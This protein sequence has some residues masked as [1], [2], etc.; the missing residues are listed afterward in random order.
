MRSSGSTDTRIPRRRILRGI[1]TLAAAATASAVVPRRAAAAPAG[2][3]VAVFGA[4]PGGMSVAHELAER[5]FRVDVYERL[6]RLGGGVRSFVTPGGG[7]DGR[8][9]LPNTCGGHFFLPGYAAMPDLLRRIPTGDGR[10]VIDRLTVSSHDVMAGGI[11]LNGTL[12]GLGVPTSPES[13]RD[14]SLDRVLHSVRGLLADRPG[15]RPTDAELLAGKIAAWVTSGDLR[16]AGQLEFIDLENGFFRADRLSPTAHTLI[17][18]L[19]QTT[20]TDSPTRG[21]NALTLLTSLVDQNLHLAAGRIT[22]AAP[23]RTPKILMDGPE[24]EVWFDPWARHLES[25]GATFHTGRTLTEI[26]FDDGRITGA[27]VRDDNGAR[28]RVEADWFVLAMPPDRL[29]PLLGP[30]LRTADPGLTGIDRLDLSVE[31]GFELFFRDPI[32]TLGGQVTNRDVDRDWLLTVVGLSEIWNLDLSEYGDGRARGMISVEFNNHPYYNSPGPT[33]RKPIKDLGYDEAFAEIRRQLVDGFPGGEKL[34]AADNFLGWRPHPTLNWDPR[35]G[36]TVP[37]LRTASAPG[38]TG[39]FPPQAG[40]IPNLF[41]V[42]GH[43]A[44]PFGLDCMES[45]AYSAK[46][47]TNALLERAGA[48]AP[49][50]ALPRTGPAPELRQLHEQDD[51]RFRA[52]LP[53]IFDTVAPAGMP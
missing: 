8:P 43:T 17:R 38:T 12:L 26:G 31:S 9:S 53:N 37:D 21:L 40:R 52:G 11:G 30:A 50:A 48:D 34:F 3:R 32:G 22:A 23:G 7:S 47:A 35:G 36:W 41:L 14:F 25:L 45:A 42:G 1:T 6:A 2:S 49:P 10:Q 13:L 28:S 29:A 44:T 20:S 24:T 46:V 27:T 33:F 15:T 39:F 16:R 51:A 4:G 18:D 5:G 19:C